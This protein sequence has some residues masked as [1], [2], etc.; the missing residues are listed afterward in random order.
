MVKGIEKLA[1]ELSFEDKNMMLGELSEKYGEPIQ[2]I[3]D[4]LDVL[5]IKK[6]IPTQLPPVPWP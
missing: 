2:R 6:G 3:M 1:Y 5:K 4:A